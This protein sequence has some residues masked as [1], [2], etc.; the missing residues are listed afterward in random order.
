[1][2]QSSIQRQKMVYFCAF[3]GKYQ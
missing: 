1:M 3:I 2:Q